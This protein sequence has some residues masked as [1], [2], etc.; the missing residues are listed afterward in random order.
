MNNVTIEPGSEIYIGSFSLKFALNL[1]I[2]TFRKTMMRN[3][4]VMD[5]ACCQKGKRKRV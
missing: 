2:N 1:K 3:A 5:C 4:F